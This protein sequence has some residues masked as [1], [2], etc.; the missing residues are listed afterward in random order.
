MP[1]FSRSLGLATLLVLGLAFLLGGQSVA[2]E[3][4]LKMVSFERVRMHD[5]VWQPRIE[6]L[7]HKTLPHAFDNTEPAQER[8]RMCAEYLER[9]RTGPKPPPHRFNT[10][11]L[12][13]VLEGAALM[14]QSEPNPEIESL[15]D[16]IIDVIARAQQED[17][18]LY[19]SH[20][21][22][23]PNVGSMGRRPYDLVRRS[24]ELY[25]MGH[26]YEAAVAYARATGKTKL[27][28]VA[29]KHARHV[30]KVFFQ[31]DPAYNDGQ[32]VNQA[33]G[34]EEIELGLVKLYHYTGKKRY[35]DMA[36]RLLDIRG[37][38]YVPGGTGTLAPS[39]AQEHAPVAEQTEAKGH[40]VRATYLYAAMAEVDSLLGSKDYSHALD[41]IWNDITDR[42]MHITGGLGAVHGIEGFGPAY[43]LPNKR[44]YLETCAAVGNVF[45]NMR[46][47]LKYRD[48]E[49]VDVAEIALLNN[50]LSGIGIDGTSFFYPN[51]L[52]ADHGHRPRSGWFGTACCPS[53][54]ARLIPQIPGYL[55]ATAEEDLYCTLY[56]A[57]STSLDLAGEKVDVKQTTDYP[58]DGRIEFQIDP[59]EAADFRLHLRIPTWSGRQLVPGDLYRYT[60]PSSGWSVEVNGETVRPRV[61]KGFAVLERT[62]RPGDHVRLTLPMPIQANTC[63]DKVEAN[64]GRIAFSRGPLVFCAEG[65]DNGGA[66]QRFFV[67]PDRALA[68]SKTTR[69]DAGILEGLPKI[70]VP[71]REIDIDGEATD[72]QLKLI[73]YFAWSNRDRSSMITWLAARKELSHP[74]PMH[75]DL[76]KFAGVKASHTFGNDTVEAVRMP[77]TPE[78]SFDRSIRR[79]TSWPQKGKTQWVE[80]EL[81]RPQEIVSVGVYWYDDH[82]GVQVPGEWHLE[83]PD[84]DGQWKTLEIYNTD[85]Y[86]SL[87]DAYNTVH[88]AESL[89][90]DRL[91][92]VMTPQHE[93]TCV[94]ILSVDV[95]TGD[96]Q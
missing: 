20:I 71:A 1:L 29:E 28:E 76:L 12:Y 96:P 74:D 85:Q 69:I 23:N 5:P 35:L 81:D 83:A 11:D 67:D 93:D 51:P 37:V 39:Y 44:A 16:R 87:P 32:P 15:M 2:A 27:L 90:T 94:G 18:Y 84:D 66:V 91:R 25:N 30:D 68:D 24:H 73:P 58:F 64:R 22:G 62:W 45:F 82:G 70:S 10:S 13:K 75:P 21:V 38:T 6:R 50:C 72:A 63:T 43:E 47:F 79:W 92:I 9:G 48:A 14:I 7:V 46:M 40:A 19:V 3:E 60:E 17:G 59:E 88:P 33:P 36:K 26:L 77:H 78:S 34:H 89:Q 95:E 86:S 8:L 61:E 52:E 80:I 42:K 57:S 53:N 55:Y 49:Y 4:A 31:G 41:S 54:I 56:A 65:I